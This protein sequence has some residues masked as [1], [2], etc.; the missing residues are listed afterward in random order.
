MKLQC[1]GPY[2]GIVLNDDATEEEIAEAM[3]LAATTEPGNGSGRIF[4]RERN[5]TDD[6][7]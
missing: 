2:G 6:T 7:K 4:Y 1:C 3:M 5:N